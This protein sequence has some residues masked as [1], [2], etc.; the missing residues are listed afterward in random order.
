M[1]PVP[2]QWATLLDEL[3]NRQRSAEAMGGV[4]R[5]DRQSARGRLDVRRRI[6]GLCDEGSF[7]EYGALGGGAD[8]GGGDHLA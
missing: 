6:A 5:I 4:E 1:R 7:V 8:P 3:G 2:E